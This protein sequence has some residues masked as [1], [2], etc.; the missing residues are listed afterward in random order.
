MRRTCSGQGIRYRDRHVRYLG[1]RV[2]SSS[3]SDPWSDNGRV[4]GLFN[5]FWSAL[6]VA[7]R[8]RYWA[9]RRRSGD[10]FRGLSVAVAKRLRPE[11]RQVLTEWPPDRNFLRLKDARRA[12]NI[13]ARSG[14]RR[15][16]HRIGRGHRSDRTLSRRGATRNPAEIYRWTGRSR[17]K[18]RTISV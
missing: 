16:V 15:H 3:S 1:P 18:G 12:R 2:T 6:W 14:L 8:R 10:V 7:W 17:W 4:A 9:N 13:P 5:G 11:R